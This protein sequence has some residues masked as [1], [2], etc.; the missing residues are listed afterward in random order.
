M[1]P[2]YSNPTPQ[3]PPPNMPYPNQPQNYP[4]PQYIP[5]TNYQ[6]YPPQTGYQPNLYPPSQTNLNNNIFPDPNCKKCNGTGYR[7]KHGENK[8]CKCIKKKE[9]EL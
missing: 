9:K 1:N 2:Q 4:P 5:P 6:Q 3:Y 7:L 8:K